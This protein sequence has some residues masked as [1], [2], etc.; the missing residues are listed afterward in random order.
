MELIE[1]VPLFIGL[2]NKNGCDFYF[3]FYVF[4]KF[5]V[6]V[7]VVFLLRFFQRVESWFFFCFF[8]TDFCYQASILFSFFFILIFPFVQLCVCVWR[9]YHNHTR[10]FLFLLCSEVFLSPQSHTLSPCGYSLCSVY[11]T[12]TVTLSCVVGAFCV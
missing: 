5:P 3:Y 12:R 8:L 7:L 9:F 10:K 4:H 1:G 11:D 6:G 2:A